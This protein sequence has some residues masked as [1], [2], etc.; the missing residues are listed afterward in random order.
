MEIELPAEVTEKASLRG[1]EFAW[2]PDDFLPALAR[3][4]SLGFACIGGQFQFRVPDGTCEIYWLAADPKDRE[5]AESWPDYVARC[6][7]EVRGG[8]TQI[9]HETNFH[10]EPESFDHLREKMAA[11]Q[12][13]P[14]DYL[15]F[16]AY[17][18]RDDA[19]N[20]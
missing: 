14:L 8:F 3:A 9:L 20:A 17:F 13:D 1:K 4:A 12:I 10:R 2:R 16:V 5:S 7:R 19:P 18:N 6:E 15:C 11:E